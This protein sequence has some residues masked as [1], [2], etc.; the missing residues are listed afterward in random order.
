MLG[1]ELHHC[2]RWAG[3]GYGPTLAEAVVSEGLACCFEV[4]F[5]GGE[6]PFYARPL[7]AQDRARVRAAF[8]EQRDRPGY[9]HQAWFYGSGEWP[10]HAG[11]ALGR[12]IV[13]RHLL[14]HG[15]SPAGLAQAPAAAF[16]ADI[17]D[18]QVV[19]LFELA[20]PGLCAFLVG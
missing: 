10:R 13:E 18:G 19:A 3:P 14:R 9:D 7:A 6:Q 16:L 17:A 12:E 5:R 15:G 4:Q 1:H 8:L 2:V 11:Y 20:A